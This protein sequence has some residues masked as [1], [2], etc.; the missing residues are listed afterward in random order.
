VNR[1][2]EDH[3]GPRVPPGLHTRA[4]AFAVGL[5]ACT[6]ALALGACAGATDQ[7]TVLRGLTMGSTWSVTV[8]RPGGVATGELERLQRDVQAQ[9]DEIETRLSTWDEASELSRFNTAAAGAGVE[10]SPLAWAVLDA[11]RAA[12]A[13]TGGAFDPTV[14][15]LVRAFGFG[16]G[17]MG[18]PPTAQQIDALRACVG[19]DHLVER[20]PVLDK[21]VDGVQLD[22]SGIAPGFAVDRLCELLDT[23]GFASYLVDVGGEIR[24]RGERSGGGPWRLAV[25]DPN[26]G[27]E[28]R[29]YSVVALSDGALATSGDY[30]NHRLVDGVEV[31]HLFDPRSLAPIAT[32][33]T[34]S[35]VLA[36]TAARADALAT[37]LAVLGGAAALEIAARLGVEVFVLERADDGSLIEFASP[38]F[39]RARLESP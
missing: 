19:M 5:V 37:A 39:T 36:S 7:Q 15:P 38:G 31:P 4:A 24:A 25:E 26:A 16:G 20:R 1:R 18:E 13:E 29:A 28:R 22:F 8:V 14:A 3:R 11:A 6:V 10:L 21:D 32:H 30:R 33:V 12:H 35:S 17:E 34:S 23:R 9:L 2:S 27:E